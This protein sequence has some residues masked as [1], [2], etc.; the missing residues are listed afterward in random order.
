[1][2]T[3]DK[4]RKLS[5]LKLRSDQLVEIHLDKIQAPPEQMRRLPGVESWFQQL[6]LKEE[7]DQ[8]ALHRMSTQ[9]NGSIAAATGSAA[10]EVAG[11]TGPTG[12]CGSRG[13]TGPTG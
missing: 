10:T 13:P 8:Q 5:R 7:R 3:T 9:I 12:P 11:P 4:D 1:M 2:P 6:R